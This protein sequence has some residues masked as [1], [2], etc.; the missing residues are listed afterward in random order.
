MSKYNKLKSKK[1][2]NSYTNSIT[3]TLIIIGLIREGTE[4]QINNSN[5]LGHHFKAAMEIPK[6]K[7]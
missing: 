3:T 5:N 6:A 2:N 7:E 4:I 1:D